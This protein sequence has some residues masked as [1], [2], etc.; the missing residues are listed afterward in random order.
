M[1]VGKVWKEKLICIYKPQ[2][3]LNF[4]GMINELESPNCVITPY[5]S[6]HPPLDDFL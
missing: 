6:N 3:G 2:M 4:A 5:A 1:D